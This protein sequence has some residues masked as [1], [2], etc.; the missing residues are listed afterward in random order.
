M[1]ERGPQCERKL[2]LVAHVAPDS[3]ALSLHGQLLR[4]P[5]GFPVKPLLA[6]P[7]GMGSGGVFG[8]IIDCLPAD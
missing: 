3:S 2:R 5:A 6:G 8:E 4:L 7:A 1:E